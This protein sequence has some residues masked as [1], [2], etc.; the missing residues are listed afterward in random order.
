M[1]YVSTAPAPRRMAILMPTSNASAT[2]NSL[3]GDATG[4][5]SAVEHQRKGVPLTALYD[6]FDDALDAANE[7]DEQARPTAE[8]F[9]EADHI[10]DILPPGG[11]S[12]EP[13]VEPSGAIA[14]VW[15][16]PEIGF[17]VLAVNGTGRLQWSAAIDGAES[18][19]T[20]A[21]LDYLQPEVQALVARFHEVNA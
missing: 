15:D 2:D 14:W 11:P 8:S 1:T 10:L 12:P 5:T 7:G 19:D 6:A 4:T 18:H 16:Y 9:R 13:V 20:L 17:L 3:F 21:L